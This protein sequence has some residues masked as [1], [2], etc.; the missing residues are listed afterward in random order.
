MCRICQGLG[1][2]RLPLSPALLT[3]NSGPRYITLDDDDE[4]N[5]VA[6]AYKEFL[7]PEC[8]P[9][10][11]KDDL[12]Q[13]HQSGLYPN[14]MVSDIT[15]R[16]RAFDYLARKISSMLPR[17]SRNVSRDDTGNMTALLS[18]VW[19]LRKEAHKKLYRSN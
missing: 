2:I 9:V 13:L 10:F 18:T 6:D 17:F 15:Y 5:V 14:P 3:S 12:E 1:R 11:Y 7:C 19:V 16:E 8:Q 4:L